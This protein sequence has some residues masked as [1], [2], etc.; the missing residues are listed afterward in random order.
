MALDRL[1]LRSNIVLCQD[2]QTTA[3]NRKVCQL[4]NNEVFQKYLRFKPMD[5]IYAFP[6]EAPALVPSC[7]LKITPFLYGHK[8]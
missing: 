5:L 6:E 8:C 2:S 4:F 3:E 7:D 1:H